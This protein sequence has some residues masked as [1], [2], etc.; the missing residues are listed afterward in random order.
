MWNES[1]IS[2]VVLSDVVGGAIASSVG[3]CIALE[4]TVT[5]GCMDRCM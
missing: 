1:C 4:Y 2:E 5:E 3:D